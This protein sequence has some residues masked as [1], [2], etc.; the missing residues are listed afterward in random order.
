MEI[1]KHRLEEESRARAAADSRILEVRLACERRRI[2]GCLRK[3][4]LYVCVQRLDVLRGGSMAEW[5]GRRT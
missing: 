2:S 3:F 4:L 5:L 1:V